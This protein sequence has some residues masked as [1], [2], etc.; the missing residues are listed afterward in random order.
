MD[1]KEKTQQQQN[2]KANITTLVRGGNRTRDLWHRSVMQRPLEQRSL[3]IAIK[4]LNYFKVIGQN[5]NKQSRFCG[6]HFWLAV[7][8]K[9]V[10]F[11]KGTSGLKFPCFLFYACER[12]GPIWVS[13]GSDIITKTTEHFLDGNDNLMAEFFRLWWWHDKL[14]LNIQNMSF[15]TFVMI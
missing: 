11:W 10:L 3:S 14:F 4:L 1:Q 5:V 9:P 15:K 2:K 7:H 8:G 12:D 13:G 6:P